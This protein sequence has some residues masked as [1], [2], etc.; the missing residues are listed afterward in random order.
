MERDGRPGAAL[1]AIWI[2]L[3]LTGLA[4]EFAAVGKARKT[5]N[6][7]SAL[8][9][10]VA[11]EMLERERRGAE[12]PDTRQT[13][14]FALLSLTM[15][16]GLVA[17]GMAVYRRARGSSVLEST[18]GPAAAWSV[19]GLITLGAGFVFA[20]GVGLFFTYSWAERAGGVGPRQLLVGGMAVNLL[21]VAVPVVVLSVVSGARAR[22]FGLRFRP[23]H[24]LQGLH[25]FLIA[26]PV[27]YLLHL[28]WSR[29][30]GDPHQQNPVDYIFYAAWRGYLPTSTLVLALVSALVVA[31]LAEEFFFR[32][33]FY[34][35]LRRVVGVAP[36][37]IA[38]SFVF[39]VL[40]SFASTVPVFALGLLLCYLYERTGSF[41]AV[42]FAH[43]LNNA[44][45]L[46]LLY[47]L[48][49]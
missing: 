23:F 31:P 13:A 24:L 36:A 16:V 7:V 37:M 5:P 4:A 22:A 27:V 9:D 38:A 18:G 26:T 39:A 30:A 15:V 48:F 40:H 33:L 42:A 17:V 19:S 11:P 46:A 35:G 14:A 47:L 44:F 45:T 41:W 12:R 25:V 10:R 1:A 6:R 20:R 28:M 49:C 8:V 2:A 34:G 32:V 29:F 3:F 21:L 43:F